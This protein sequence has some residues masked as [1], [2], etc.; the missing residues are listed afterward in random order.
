[1][2]LTCEDVT[3]YRV[4]PYHCLMRPPMLGAVPKNGLAYVDFRTG[5]C[6]DGHPHWGTALYSWKLTDEEVEH[7]ELRET[8]FVVTD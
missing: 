4:Y 7:Y 3:K 6:S 8:C 2:M 1:M 5:K